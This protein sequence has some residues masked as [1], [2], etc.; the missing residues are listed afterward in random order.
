M[1]S[2]AL[3]LSVSRHSPE[4]SLS[5]EKER[6]KQNSF[7]NRFGVRTELSRNPGIEHHGRGIPRQ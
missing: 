3:D 4:T 6:K 5:P 7:R 1:Q 2:R